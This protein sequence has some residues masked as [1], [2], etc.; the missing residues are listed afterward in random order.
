MTD[1]VHLFLHQFVTTNVHV[2][3]SCISCQMQVTVHLLHEQS[4]LTS[5]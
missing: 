4:H 1:H 5:H 2:M 3:L